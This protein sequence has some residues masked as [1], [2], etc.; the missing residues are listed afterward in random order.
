MS[1]RQT[2]DAGNKVIILMFTESTKKEACVAVR[3]ILADVEG[4][5]FEY[6]G[7][8]LGAT[9]S[10]GVASYPDDG[11]DLQ[12]IMG[13]ADEALFTSKKRG[14]NQLTIYSPAEG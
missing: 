1:M 9:L 2:G 14:K 7:I 4:A 11:D 5:S 3:R 10:A 8:V 13:R 12:T 6:R